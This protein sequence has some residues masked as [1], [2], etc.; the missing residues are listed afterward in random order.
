MTQE[1]FGLDLFAAVKTVG[2]ILAIQ[3]QYAG[4]VHRSNRAAMETLLKKR[5]GLKVTLHAQMDALSDANAAEIVRRYPWVL[6]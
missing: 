6:S 4:A 2:G 5:D 1:E 3:Q